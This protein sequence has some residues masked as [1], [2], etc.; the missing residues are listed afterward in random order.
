MAKQKINVDRNTPA[1]A[2]SGG[3]HHDG[4]AAMGVTRR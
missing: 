1:L 3:G 2:L 4:E